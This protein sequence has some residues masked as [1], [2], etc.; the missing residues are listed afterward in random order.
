MVPMITL[1]GKKQLLLFVSF[2]G[3]YYPP[4]YSTRHTTVTVTVVTCPDVPRAV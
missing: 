2:D 3:P 1:K 4:Y